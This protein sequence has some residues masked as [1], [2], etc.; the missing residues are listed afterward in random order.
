MTAP[1]NIP[2][3]IEQNALGPKRVQ[4]G[5]TSVEQHP[6]QD[7]IAA[8]RQTANIAAAADPFNAFKRAKIVP[9]GGG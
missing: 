5:N 6:I 2:D 3:A 8:E 7:Q 9:P 4:V 1:D